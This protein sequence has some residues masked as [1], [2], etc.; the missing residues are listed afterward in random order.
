M[1][2]TLSILVHADSK[3]GK[4]TLGATCPAPVLIL[5]AEGSTKFLPVAKIEWDP[6]QYAPPVYDG[7]WTHCIVVVRDFETLRV[8]FQWLIHGQHQFRSIVMDSISE[9]QR[10][11]KTAIVGTE[12]M[13]MQE[14]GELLTKMD[15]L[16]RGYRDLTLHPTNPIQV[17]M[18][19]AETRETNGKW[20]P[21]MQG[22]I[23]V[24]LPY[25]MDLVGYLF[26]ADVPQPDQSVVRQRQL[27]IA[28]HPQYEAG[29]RVQGRL[30]DVI[31]E[32]NIAAILQAVYPA[33]V[34]TQTEI[35]MEGTPT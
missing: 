21:Y 33:P 12:Q 6:T 16:I 11:L 31:A 17:A 10:K 15:G 29:E 13:K 23:S 35:P 32:P 34:N 22:Q 25:W 4:S 9:M 30:P 20:R 1:L 8:T 5:D 7:T 28:P 3:V 19:I 14:W 24:A 2:E 26:V 18:F 27:L